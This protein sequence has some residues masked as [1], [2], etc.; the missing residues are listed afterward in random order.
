MRRTAQ[1]PPQAEVDRLRADLMG[2]FADVFSPEGELP[3]MHGAPMDIVLNPDATPH[4]VNGARP[5]P[6]AYRDLLKGQLDDMLAKN[7]IEP[8][9]RTWPTLIV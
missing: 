1:A 6:F 4:C 8:V 2:E 9:C 3:P 5:V 7:I